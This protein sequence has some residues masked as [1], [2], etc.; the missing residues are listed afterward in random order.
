M[1]K[2]GS[3]LPLWSVIPFAGILLSIALMPLLAAKFWHHHYGKVAFFWS[4]VMIVP[5]VLAFK[6]SAVYEILHIAIIDYIPFIIMLWALFTVSGGIMIKGKFDGKPGTNLM[7]LGIGTV[8]ASLIGTTGAAMVMI[9]PL[10]RS[11]SRRKYKTHIFVFCIFLVANIGGSLTPLGDPPLFLGFLHGVSFFWTLHLLPLMG[12]LSIFLLVIFY[13]LDTY[14]YKKEDVT[15]N[16]TNNTSPEPF[17]VQGWH[18]FI[19]LGGVIGAVLLSGIVNLGDVIVPGG[20]HV[21]ISGLG[22]D[23]IFI[24]MGVLSL[25]TTPRAIREA[26][27]FTWAPIREVA[28]LFAGIFCTII[29]PLNILKAGVN[30]SMAFIIHAVKEPWHYF[31]V[32][33]G[34]SSFLDNAPT[35]L[36]FF[37]TELGQFFS[38]MKEAQAVNLLMHTKSSYLL[39]ISA[40]SVF[41]G[42]NTYIGNAP[43]FMIKSIAEENGISMPS[44]FGYMFKYSL[45]ILIPCFIALT[46]IFF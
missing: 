22:R 26:N 34:L 10:I 39:A 19:F 1:E 46:F 21:D 2:I 5:F 32:S 29:P 13:F 41:M 15:E 33:G 6:Q 25:Q 16:N 40:G 43:N 36:T 12:L 18:N 24:L 7:M 35:Y 3:L 42:A 14:F 9:R 45:I 30:G 20:I 28:I 31:W 11:N 44:F 38:G 17:G 23:V 27:G 4:L 8:L 37:N